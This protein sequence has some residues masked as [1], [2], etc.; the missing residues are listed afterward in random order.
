MVMEQ[1]TCKLAQTALGILC[2]VFIIIYDALIYRA[3]W[4]VA[5]KK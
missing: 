1:E 5:K 2:C 4:C 3:R